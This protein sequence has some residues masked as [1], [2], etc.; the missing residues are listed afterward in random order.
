MPRLFTAL[1]IPSD[2]SLRL[3]LL[4]GGLPGAK[5][6][7]REDFHINLNFIGEVDGRT[8]DDI[9]DLM[10][11]MEVEPF[12]LN[13]DGVGCFGSNK[14]RALYA[15]IAPCEPLFRLHQTLHHHFKLMGLSPDE[16]QYFPHIR[17]GRLRDLSPETVARWLQRQGGLCSRSFDTTAI[18]LYSSRAR[19]GGRYRLEA[20]YPLEQPKPTSA[21]DDWD[22]YLTNSHDPDQD[23]S[24]ST[25]SINAAAG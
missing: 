14:P 4:S 8:A 23:G 7:D 11:Q 16:R 25:Q 24:W 13:V 10:A 15:R 12:L 9:A 19:K 1:P 20:R 18:D 5:W 3:S 17:L 2:I 22:A 21:F 6:A